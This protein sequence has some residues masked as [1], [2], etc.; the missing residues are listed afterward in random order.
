MLF[1]T[2]QKYSNAASEEF[3]KLTELQDFLTNDL[4]RMNAKIPPDALK[5]ITSTN[6]F[7]SACVSWP[8]VLFLFHFLF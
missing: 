1:N 6:T 3:T 2:L 8:K 7:I 4:L 5:E